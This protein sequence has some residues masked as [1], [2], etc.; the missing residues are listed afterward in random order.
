MGFKWIIEG[1]I[2][3]CLMKLTIG[4]CVAF[5]KRIQDP[6]ILDLVTECFDVAGTGSN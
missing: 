1:D 6:Q 5:K 2:A 3:A 4:Y